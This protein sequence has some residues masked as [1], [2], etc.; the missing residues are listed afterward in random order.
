M[1]K[2]TTL[3]VLGVVAHH[4]RW[5]FGAQRGG[6]ARGALGEAGLLDAVEWH[7]L[8][9]EQPAEAC[10]ALLGREGRWRRWRRMQV[11]AAATAVAWSSRLL[12][13]AL[14]LQCEG[15]RATA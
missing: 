9:R 15:G 5:T 6:A 4:D 12:D 11:A 13:C 7:R 8:L 3:V 10:D 2:S 14:D 1:V